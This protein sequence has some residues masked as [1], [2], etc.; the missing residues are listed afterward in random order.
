MRHRFKDELEVFLRITKRLLR[1]EQRF[2]QLGLCAFGS[3]LRHEVSEENARPF[4]P[5]RIRLF[6]GDGVLEF[7]I[8][9][10]AAGFQV[11]EEHLAGLQ[12]PLLDNFFFGKCQYAHFRGHQHDVI[13]GDQVTRRTQAIAVERR[14]D[15]AAIGK[16][17]CCR[18]IPGF[19]QRR[20]KF[21][22]VTALLINQ[23]VACPGFGDQHHHCVGQRITAHD[24]EFQRIVEAGRVGLAI[25]DQR[26]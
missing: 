14:A 1:I 5:F 15:L 20:M 10:D 24:Q 6:S 18:A 11:D 22:E 19:H 16:G 9:D 26:P 21:V 17:D 7:G 13:I 12:A 23:P 25:D 4:Y 8:V 2:Q 3:K